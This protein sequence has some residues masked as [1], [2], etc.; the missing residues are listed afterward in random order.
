MPPTGTGSRRPKPKARPAADGHVPAAV[1]GVSARA[2]AAA[3]FRR[4]LCAVDGSRASTAAIRTAATLAGDGG[5]LTLLTV[6]A[7]SGSG[8]FAGAEVSHARAERLLER[9]QELAA[10]AGVQ[11]RAML[12]P[13]GPP[14][15]VILEHARGHDLLVIGAP[16]TSWLAGLV[17]GG[18][19]HAALSE[20]T[21]PMLVVRRGFAAGLKGRT[22]LVA[23]D[24]QS[25]SDD[26]V[27]LAGEV[28]RAYGAGVT[29]VHALAS[30]TASHPRRV[31][32]QQQRLEQEG[33]PSVSARLQPGRPPEVILA[34]AAVVRPAVIVLGSRRLRGVRTVGSV[35]R[36]VMHEAGCSVLVVPPGRGEAQPKNSSAVS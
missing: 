18:V 25:S 7:E 20:F 36:R 34:A 28:G 17:L 21:T 35:S 26:V 32:A 33:T 12:D 4:I 14:L 19:A 11:A 10:D 24:G 5:A 22:L 27:E 1:R 8:A 2:E 16:V 6:T 31:R 3:P 15:E 23:S 30:E 29:I 9:G 13:A